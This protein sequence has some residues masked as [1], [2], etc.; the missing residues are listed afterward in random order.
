MA[1]AVQ[2][3][4]FGH[5]DRHH[6]KPWGRDGSRILSRYLLPQMRGIR[7][8]PSSTPEEKQ[9]VKD[10]YHPLHKLWEQGL[11]GEHPLNDD[12][13]DLLRELIRWYR[14]PG[15]HPINHFSDLDP[16]RSMDDL[17]MVL[18]YVLV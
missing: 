3:I 6:D 12:D 1:D 17:L 16:Y 10:H 2:D 18:E 14:R 13:R 15:S 4:L 5:Q 11:E 8:S 9:W 7:V